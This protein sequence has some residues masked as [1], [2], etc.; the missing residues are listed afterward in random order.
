LVWNALNTPLPRPF[1]EHA[2]LMTAL[3]AQ[4]RDMLG[5]QT[6]RSGVARLSHAPDLRTHAFTLS[7]DDAKMQA[8]LCCSGPVQV[9]LIDPTGALIT[10]P[11]REPRLP[12]PPLDPA[13]PGRDPRDWH[14]HTQGIDVRTHRQELT[15]TIDLRHRRARGLPT[16]GR[17]RLLVFHGM[18]A[19]QAHQ[20]WRVGVP[21]T[22]LDSPRLNGPAWTYALAVDSTIRLDIERPT[23]PR[24]GQALH[25]QPKLSGAD[26]Q[27]MVVH[28]SSRPQEPID[29]WLDR[30]DVDPDRL[31]QIARARPHLS[32]RERKAEALAQA[33]RSAPR[34]PARASPQPHLSGHLDRRRP[35]PTPRH[36]RDDRARHRARQRRRHGRT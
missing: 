9:A 30:T 4:L 34:A 7:A 36:L 19:E 11:Q 3:R 1:I 33:G 24:L 26:M 28:R 15:V 22:P 2:A 32:G 27:T 35:A 17:W 5:I 21:H 13:S 29:A 31:Q 16:D 6:I 14:A 12:R 25:L 10:P 23:R 8:V 20:R 18:T